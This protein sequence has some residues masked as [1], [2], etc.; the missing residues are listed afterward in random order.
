MWFKKQIANKGADVP[1]EVDTNAHA[2]MRWGLVVLL[3]G[4]GGFALWA[5]FAPLDAGVTANAYVQVAGNRK[6]IQHLE[7]GTIEEI[8]VREGDKVHAGQV[9]VHLNPTRARAEQGVVSSQYIVAKAVQARL[10]AERDGTGKIVQDPAFVERFKDDPRYITA[11]R[12][13]QSLYETR[14]RALE[15]EIGILKE[16]QRGAEQQL[17]GLE[18]VQRNRRQQIAYIGRE[19]AGVR[20][21]AREGYLPRNRMFELERDAA[22]LQAALSTDIVDAGRTRNQVSEL[23]LRILQRT[24]DYQKEVQSQLSDIQ[25][26]VTALGDRL[27]ALDYSVQETDIRSPIDGTIM[28]LQI[29]TVGGVVAPGATLME[30]VPN[31]APYLVQAQVPVQSIDRVETGLDVEIT[32][33]AFNHA[34]TPNIPGKVLTV[35]ADRLTDPKG[36]VPYYLAQV[37][38]TP[39]GVELLGQNT[40]RPG[41]PASVMIRTG[42]RTML[43]Y[44][45]KPLLERVDRSFKEQ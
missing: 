35:S 34:R 3:V 21:L 15:G 44:L 37:E 31:D 29:H 45:L 18:E 17:R 2:P 9:L 25:K 8:L 41:M 16:N 6:A 20:D 28:N 23:K 4:F 19:L 42:E 43:N 13:Q 39:E 40:I 22:Q 7:G 24:Q 32:F 12:A 27:S 33:P 30:V 14:T 5:A 11:T 1:A 38:V 36:E 10:L 26:E